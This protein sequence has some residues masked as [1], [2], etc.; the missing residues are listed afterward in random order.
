MINRL[1][2]FRGPAPL[3]HTLLAGRTITGVTVQTLHHQSFDHGV[4]VSQTPAPGFNIPNP[5]YCTVPELLS[6]VAP[7]GAEMLVD[8]IDKGLYVPPIKDEGWRSTEDTSELIH[9]S[10][11]TPNDR[12]VNW[13]E[14]TS[15]DITRRDRV[16][17]PL[18]SNAICVNNGANEPR[19]FQEKRVIFTDTEETEPPFECQSFQKLPG[20]PFADV[21]HSD[22]PGNGHLY[23]FTADGKVR[24]INRMKVEGEKDAAALPAARKARMLGE[25]AAQYENGQLIP[26]HGPFV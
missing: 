7:K 13:A 19:S 10:K 4:I 1:A 6:L 12:H 18:W 5:T 20:L 8:S 17:G 3:H 11:I 25:P 21:S 2:S 16:I 26:F 9:A 24:R 14:W 22:Q 23:V 15:A